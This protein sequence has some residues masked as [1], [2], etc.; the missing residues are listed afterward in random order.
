[1]GYENTEKKSSSCNSLYEL[2]E[3]TGWLS[4]SWKFE[5]IK[6][7]S[8]FNDSGDRDKNNCITQNKKIYI[9]TKEKYKSR[10]PVYGKRTGTGMSVDEKHKKISQD[11]NTKE[12]MEKTNSHK[13]ENIKNIDNQS[14]N[15]KSDQEKSQCNYSNISKPV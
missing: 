10:L 8:I 2:T 4:D 13:N 12:L 15:K 9:S 3:K 6:N 11:K 1:M 7:A 5:T 14:S